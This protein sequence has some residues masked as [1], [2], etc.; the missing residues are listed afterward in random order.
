MKKVK[1]KKIA[2]LT[3]LITTC[4]SLGVPFVSAE[5]DIASNELLFATAA[6][7]S[8]ESNDEMVSVVVGDIN[9]DGLPDLTDLT[10]LSV[11]LMLGRTA[12]LDVRSQIAS[13]IDKNGTVDIADLPRMR[14]FI[15]KDSSVRVLGTVEVPASMFE[16]TSGEETVTTDVTA[17]VTEEA[18]TTDV[19]ADVTEEAVTTDVTADTTEE[20]VTTDITTEATIDE[21]TVTKF[22]ADIPDPNDDAVKV[23][24][25]DFI[26][27]QRESAGCKPLELS[28]ELSYVADIRAKELEAKIGSSRPDGSSYRTLLS[29]YDL[30]SVHNI[31]LYSDDSS[32]QNYISTLK[33][34]YMEMITN[35]DVRKI[36]I[37]HY[38]SGIKN[39]WIVFITY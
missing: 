35:N 12:T 29:E 6:A 38:T 5:D 3:A 2:G 25:Y 14:Q 9:N 37:G 16:N 20:A 31:Q 7:P 32:V 1:L 21:T 33:S 34:G 27:S 13:D 23:Q 36:G 28:K 19:T 11:N 26:A 17:D 10:L 22:P 18:V 8:N 4:A 30:L 39:Y 24:I 15:S